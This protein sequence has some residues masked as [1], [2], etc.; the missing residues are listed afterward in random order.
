MDQFI[1]GRSYD[2]YRSTVSELSYSWEFRGTVAAYQLQSYSFTD[3]TTADGD[4]I[5]PNYHHYRIV[6]KS[7]SADLY[8]IS[9]PDSGYSEDNI[10]PPSP[11]SPWAA[12]NYPNPFNPVTTIR[13]L[14]K[15]GQLMMIRLFSSG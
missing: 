1:G 11:V 7:S 3:S 10:S 6:A 12:Q 5:D 2:V 15:P 4:L 8:W 9:P 13:L 14:K